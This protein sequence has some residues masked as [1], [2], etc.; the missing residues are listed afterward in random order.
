MLT[1]L[2]KTKIIM[3]MILKILIIL[4]MASAV[5]S[6]IR[7]FY[8][9]LL[10][11]F[12]IIF[13]TLSDEPPAVCFSLTIS[14]D[15]HGFMYDC[16]NESFHIFL[17]SWIFHFLSSWIFHIFLTFISNFSQTT[18]CTASILTQRKLIFAEPLAASKH[19]LHQYHNHK[20]IQY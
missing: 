10:G 7:F 6:S 17:S 20:L 5:Y 11:K 12:I 16:W 3:I 9:P 13:Y 15:F 19:T 4:R 2:I 1:L 18:S 14:T 8:T